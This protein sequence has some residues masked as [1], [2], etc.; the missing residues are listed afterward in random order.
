M[1][2]GKRKVRQKKSEKV[3][4]VAKVRGS[5]SE[6]KNTVQELQLLE[7]RNIKQSS[8]PLLES[9]ALGIGEDTFSSST[10]QTGLQIRASLEQNTLNRSHT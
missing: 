7:F 9:I 5:T 8:A 10:V 2:V 3:L 6:E 4:S 1:E